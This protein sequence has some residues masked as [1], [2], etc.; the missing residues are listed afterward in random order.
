MRTESAAMAA[1]VLAVVEPGP[2]EEYAMCAL[3]AAWA[4]PAKVDI[5]QL[6][7]DGGVRFSGSS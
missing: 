7:Y 6:R 4:D 5:G 2:T 3:V 1:E